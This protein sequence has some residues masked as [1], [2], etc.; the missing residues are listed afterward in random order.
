MVTFT[1]DEAASAEVAA[2]INAVQ[3]AAPNLEDAGSASA[4]RS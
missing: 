2:L 1:E 3:A 4:S